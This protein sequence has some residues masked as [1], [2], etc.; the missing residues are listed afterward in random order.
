MEL[1]SNRKE[2]VLN[3]SNPI[4]TPPMWRLH[5]MRALFFMNFISLGLDNWKTILFP[6]EQLDT[7]SGVAIS[8]W[9]SFAILNF[10]GVRFPLKMIPILMLQF[11]YKISWSIGVYFPARKMDY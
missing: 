9:A 6:Q 4:T 1:A 2:D 11:L 5:I 8:F 7:L 10:I 3:S